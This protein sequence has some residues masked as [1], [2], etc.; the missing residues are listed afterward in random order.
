MGKTET[1]KERSIY[2]YLRT[3]EQK[4]KWEE[5]AKKSGLSISKWISKN[6]EDSL[7]TPEERK[8]RP[9]EE[10]EEENE[11]LRKQVADLMEKLRQQTI[12]RDK[13]EREIRKYRAEPFLA[14]GFEGVRQYDKE[15]VNLLRNT[16]GV[17]G[18]PKVLSDREIMEN[19][20]IHP[21]E[22][23]AVKALTKQLDALMQYGLV[24]S[25][26]KGWR[27]TK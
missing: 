8:S 26:P 7:L 15:L 1:I 5:A 6:V 21:T 22:E 27:W 20:G 18:K 23:E 13:L 11:A 16:K 2:V 3:I 24:E 10:L 17:D 9:Q 12:I 14:P 4:K 19:L 25:L